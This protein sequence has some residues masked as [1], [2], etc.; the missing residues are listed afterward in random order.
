MV[1]NMSETETEFLTQTV[2]GR[3]RSSGGRKEDTSSLGLWISDG[4]RKTEVRLT[5]ASRWGVSGG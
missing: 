4:R 3:A 1:R 5:I 2:F